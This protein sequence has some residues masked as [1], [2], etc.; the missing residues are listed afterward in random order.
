VLSVAAMVNLRL[1][2]VAAAVDAVLTVGYATT[3]LAAAMTASGVKRAEAQRVIAQAGDVPAL[4]QAAA[5]LGRRLRTMASRLG[6]VR[7]G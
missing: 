7:V 1:R 6:A 5:V 2:S 4:A 3:A